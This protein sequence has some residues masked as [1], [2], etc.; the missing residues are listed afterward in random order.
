MNNNGQD[1]APDAELWA[2][3]V[4]LWSD[5]AER[6]NEQGRQ[7][8]DAA[9]TMADPKDWRRRSLDALSESM[10]IYMRSPAFLAAMK[11]NMEAVIQ[12]KDQ[13]DNV[14]KEFARNAGVPTTDDISGLFERMHSLEVKILHKLEGIEQRLDEFEKEREEPC[15][16]NQ[17]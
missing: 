5:Y 16:A 1:Q 9:G 13:V 3:L 4:R 7:W 15:A 17:E 11:R 10:D 14:S 12:T 8:L 2:P 6:A